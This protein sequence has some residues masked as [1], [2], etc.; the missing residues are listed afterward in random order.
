[1]YREIAQKASV[2][3]ETKIAKASFG[4]L[5]GVWHNITCSTS[6]DY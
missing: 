3:F 6:A 2:R 4:S 5:L 1:M